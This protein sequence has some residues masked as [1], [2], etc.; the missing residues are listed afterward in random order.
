LK[1]FLADT[2]TSEIALGI[3]D[4]DKCLF[5]SYTRAEKR[6]SSMIMGLIDNAVKGSGLKLDDIDVFGSTLGP[7]AFTGIRVG[8]SVMKGFGQALDK[9]FIGISTLEI[10]AQQAALDGLRICPVLDARRGEVYTAVYNCSGGAVSL[11]SG[12]VLQLVEELPEHMLSKTVAVIL[13]RDEAFGPLISGG[14][15]ISVRI[16]DHLDMKSFNL[17]LQRNPDAAAGLKIYDAAPL[18][19]RKSDAEQNLEKPGKLG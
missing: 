16:V 6:F 9:K 18:Y 5:E 13:K 12:P 14:D 1:A 19:V 7:G 8:M 15:K 11:V 2:S 3:F 10:M 4:G 17:I